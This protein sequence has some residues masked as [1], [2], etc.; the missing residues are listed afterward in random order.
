MMGYTDRHA[1]YFLRLISRGVT[2]N[3]E[4]A[5]MTTANAANTP[6]WFRASELTIFRQRNAEAVVKLLI[7]TGMEIF[8]MV[9]AMDP[10]LL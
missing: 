1:R 6:I 9:S 7:S 8:R 10:F 5:E 4:S 3:T 2:S